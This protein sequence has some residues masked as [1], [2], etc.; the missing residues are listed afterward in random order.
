MLGSR[1]RSASSLFVLTMLLGGA[2]PGLAQP[3]I[4][5]PTA[6]VAGTSNHIASVQS[7]AGSSFEWTVLGG[8]VDTGSKLHAIT[9]TAGEPGPLRL[10][11][12]E[13]SATGQPLGSATA[14]IEVVA[15]PAWYRAASRTIPIVLSLVGGR[16]DF[17]S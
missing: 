13:K 17:F 9:F 11:V 5:A 10:D 1:P 8:R 2:A 6:V 4:V 7:H 16:G 3:A 14:M 12:V 15:Q